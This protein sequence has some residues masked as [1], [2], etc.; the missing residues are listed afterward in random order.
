MSTWP[1]TS[2][3]TPSNPLAW[4]DLNW[5]LPVPRHKLKMVELDLLTAQAMYKQITGQDV[6]IQ[7]CYDEIRSKAFSFL[8]ALE[9]GDV[10]LP[11]DRQMHFHIQGHTTARF[12]IQ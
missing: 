7:M 1:K 6:T 3:M 4:G 5:D 10:G 8:K 2:M 12:I 11:T 9:R